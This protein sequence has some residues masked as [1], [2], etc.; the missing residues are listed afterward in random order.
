[1]KNFTQHGMTLVEMLVS[2]G[3]FTM[4]LALIFNSTQELYKNSGYAQA[5]AYEIDNVRRGLNTFARDVRQMT[6]SDDGSFPVALK[7]NYIF[8]FYS[9]ID[10]DSSVEYLEYEIATT[11]ILYKRVYNSVGSPPVYDFDNPDEE[12]ILSDYVQNIIQGI[13]AFE[14]YDSNGGLLDDSS[15]LTDVR[16]IRAKVIVN[17]DPGRSPG[18]FMLQTS[19]APRNLKDNL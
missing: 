17:I 8:G 7:E 5:Q 9:N 18:E 1:M 16:Y 2:I 11:T 14:Y 4:L 12:Y 13:D 15:L 3:L 19:I 6:Y 10:D